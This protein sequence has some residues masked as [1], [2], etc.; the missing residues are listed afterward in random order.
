VRQTPTGTGRTDSM[1]VIKDIGWGM[2]VALFAI[3]ELID[4]RS[5]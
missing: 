4:R 3:A 2:I 1:T 5:K